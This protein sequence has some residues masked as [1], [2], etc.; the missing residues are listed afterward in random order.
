MTIKEIYLAAHAAVLNVEQ[1]LTDA[2]GIAALNP[3]KL[4]E[5]KLA[6]FAATE[7]DAH[8]LEAFEAHFDE[9][10]AKLKHLATMQAPSQMLSAAQKQV[11]ESRNKLKAKQL[12]NEA[13]RNPAPATVAQVTPQ[14]ATQSNTTPAQALAPT[15]TP[16]A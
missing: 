11:V 6:A 10:A 16:A 4:A 2:G 15:A 8:D 3:V 5:T 12:E 7:L 9:I 14:P 13:R 1:K